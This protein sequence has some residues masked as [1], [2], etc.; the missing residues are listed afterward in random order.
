MANYPDD[1][2]QTNTRRGKQPVAGLS[3]YHDDDQQHLMQNNSSTQHDL[4]SGRG[5]RRNIFDEMYMSP[6]SMPPTSSYE[7]YQRQQAQSRFPD[8]LPYRQR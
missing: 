7:L 8:A 6:I 4:S 5:Q 2:Q 3:D 1:Y